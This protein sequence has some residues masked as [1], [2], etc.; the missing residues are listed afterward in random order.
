MIKSKRAI[1]LSTTVFAYENRINFNIRTTNELI[2]KPKNIDC[3]TQFTANEGEDLNRYRNS[4]KPILN[5]VSIALL[6][7]Q[8]INYNYNEIR[9]FTKKFISLYSNNQ[10]SI[11]VDYC[12]NF[13]FTKCCDDFLS[14]Q[15]AQSALF[16]F[17][18]KF[19]TLLLIYQPIQTYYF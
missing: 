11:N 9:I 6:L 18:R 17:Y 3:K 14:F 1:A 10:I 8:I 12:L 2:A 4:L 19:Y 16:Q 13:I 15:K 7:C 5:N